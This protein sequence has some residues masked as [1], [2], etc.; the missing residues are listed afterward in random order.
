M[1]VD[2][3]DHH[4]S[5]LQIDCTTSGSSPMST[6]KKTSWIQYRYVLI[7]LGFFGLTAVY[8]MRVN[9]N[10][11]MVA[12]VN[13]SAVTKKQITGNCPTHSITTPSVIASNNTNTFDSFNVRHGKVGPF[14]WDLYTQGVIL[15]AFYYGYIITPI[16]GGRMAEKYGAKWLFGCGTLLTG[17]LSLLI[18]AASTYGGATGLVIVRILQGLGEGVTYPAIEAQIAHWVPINQRATAI[19]LIHTGGFFGVAIG[20]YISGVLAASD[21]LGGWPSIF[22][23]FG[24]VTAFWFVLWALL[25][26]NRPDDHPWA[27][28]EEIDLILSD[29]GDQ[30]PSH[31]GLYSAVPYT[32]AIVA[33]ALSGPA[34]DWLRRNQ[35]MTGTNIRKLC[36]GL[37]HLIPSIMLI[38]VVKVAGCDGSLSLVLFITA[39]T[40]RGISEAGYM[41]IPVDMA[42]DY[43]GTILGICVCIGNTTGF[44]VPWI[45]GAIIETQNTTTTWSYIFYLAGGI[46]LVTGVMFQLFASAEVQEWGLVSKGTSSD[47]GTS[48][49]NSYEPPRNTDKTI[50]TSPI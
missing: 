2:I 12:M 14:T 4:L 33:G 38:S 22:Y 28:Q 15:G 49:S 34:A 6:R 11:A 46:G 25:I 31:N 36:N 21:I 10:V 24:I 7:I 23:F 5:K 26:S 18:P 29:L 19:S 30:K 41:S 37:A 17:L 42:P 1:T 47:E 40:I 32:G 27:S 35:Y 45:T 13:S 20:M 16:P 9:L 43:A 50:L 44:L 39:G 3:S 8:G 48:G